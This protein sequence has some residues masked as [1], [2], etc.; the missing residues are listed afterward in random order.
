MHKSTGTL[1][2][3]TRAIPVAFG[4]K[5]D[6]QIRQ[7]LKL[8]CLNILLTTVVCYVGMLLFPNFMQL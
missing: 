7:G 6:V 3:S 4:L 8:T 5:T 1:P 2:V